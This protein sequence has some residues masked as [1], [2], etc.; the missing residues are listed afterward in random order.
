[1][2]HRQEALVGSPQDN[3]KV[4]EEGQNSSDAETVYFPKRCYAEK[5]IQGLAE[6]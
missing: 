1:M 5:I 2:V 6:N 4:G 3:P